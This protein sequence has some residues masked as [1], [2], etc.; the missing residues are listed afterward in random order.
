MYYKNKGLENF[1]KEKREYEEILKEIDKTNEEM[2]RLSENE[3]VKQYIEAFQK[4]S[5]LKSN[6]EKLK[7]DLIVQTMYNCD[8]YFVITKIESIFDGHRTDTYKIIKCIHC[9]LTNAYLDNPYAS[10]PKDVMNQIFMSSIS[11]M[12]SV[13]EVCHGRYSDNDIPSLKQSYDAIKKQYP[14]ATD[15]DI[16]KQIKLIKK[17]TGK[18]GGEKC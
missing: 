5:T 17:M 11:S 9:G 14:N 7:K 12:S 10:F 4:N 13:G 15:Y 16:E 18:K 2:R 8:H 1:E 3:V 6:E